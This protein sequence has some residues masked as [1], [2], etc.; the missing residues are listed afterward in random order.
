[1][2]NIASEVDHASGDPEMEEW[3]RQSQ[4]L[5]YA[6]SKISALACVLVLM[7]LAHLHNVSN[8]FMDELFSFIRLDVLPPSNSLPKTRHEHVDSL[9]D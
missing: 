1:V 5:L 8:S 9:I 7:N 3:L 2:D 4:V 6:S